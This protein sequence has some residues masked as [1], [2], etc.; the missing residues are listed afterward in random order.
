MWD[1]L[2]GDFD[3]KITPEKCLKNVIGNAKA[4]SIIVFHDSVKAWPRLE[5]ALP[6]TLQYF[7][8]Q[9]YE[10]RTLPQTS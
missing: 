3:T 2:S 5:Y 9:G 7:T 10:F 8:D 4:G 6:K 1:V